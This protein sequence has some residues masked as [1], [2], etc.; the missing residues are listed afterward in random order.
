M[1]WKVVSKPTVEPITVE[2]AR[3]AQGITHDADDDLLAMWI[4]AAREECEHMIGRAVAPQ[5]LQLALDEF[6][7]GA[8]LLPQSPVI[9]VE[10]LKYATAGGYADV[11]LYETYLDDSQE[12]VWLM[13]AFG[14]AWPSVR[15]QAN[16]VLVT[17]RAGYEECPDLI[18]AW[19]LL[20]V[21]A[22]YLNRESDSE[23]PAQRS[24]FVDRLLDRYRVI[25][26]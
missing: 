16:A 26:L 21:G 11:P 19:I 15:T 7:A 17:Y 10:S 20:R 22:Y 8:I 4:S 23:K 3:Q 2:E 18:R 1:G 24:P 14:G 12:Q 6:P 25:A 5:T 13:P 9:S